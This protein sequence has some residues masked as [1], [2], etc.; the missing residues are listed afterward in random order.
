ML[1]IT[2]KIVV[3]FYCL[4]II[5]LGGI[6]ISSY[7]FLTKLS[8]KQSAELLLFCAIVSVLILSV[9][10][11][12]MLIRA[13]HRTRT[14]QNLLHKIS[15][16]GNLDGNKLKSFGDFGANILALV[17]EI[18]D[19]SEKRA[20][21][22]RYLNAALRYLVEKS[23]NALLLLDSEGTIMQVSEEFVSKFTKNNSAENICGTSIEQFYAD[24]PF[25]LLAQEMAQ[26]KRDFSV[27]TENYTIHFTPL[28]SENTMPD[29]FFAIIQKT[30]VFNKMMNWSGSAKEKDSSDKNEN[31]SKAEADNSEQKNISSFFKGIFGSKKTKKSESNLKTGE[32][33]E[34]SETSNEPKETE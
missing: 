7:I 21:R 14:L 34:N 30:S 23:N 24:S 6:G 5:F 33:S 25:L 10:F 3:L 31:I 27:S 1:C 12:G 11:F 9:I 32:S 4:S 16:G 20:Q 13:K 28:F 26:T 19:V 8:Q 17:H 22:I 2:S 29:G 18:Q 15:V